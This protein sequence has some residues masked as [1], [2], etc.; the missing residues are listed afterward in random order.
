MS[1][2]G[3]GNAGFSDAELTEILR[4]RP[5]DDPQRQEACEILVGR[6]KNL[7]ESCVFRYRDVPE[8]VED[9]MQVGYV[10]LMKAINNYDPEIGSLAAYAQPSVSGEIKRYFRDKRWHMRVKRPAQELR[11]RIRTAVAELTQAL[12]RSPRPAELAEHLQVSEAEITE[13][14]LASEVFQLPSLDSPLG[15]E[16]DGG[17]LADQ[18][19]AEDPKLEHTLDMQAVWQH[20][21]ELPER[22]QRLL[23]MRFYG[24]MT[25]L[26]IAEKLGVSQM[27]VSRLLS[28]ALGYLRDQIQATGEPRAEAPLAEDAHQ[29][30]QEAAPLG[31]ISDPGGTHAGT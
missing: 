14:L 5:L 4:S 11:L 7:V 10:G 29:V 22:E 1:V 27:H 13:A 28:R 12:A 21:A 17:T 9:L 16:A 20:A 26:Q 24:N 25:Q 15:P 31:H 6:Y 2:G 3:K 8:S 23:M 18:V 19:G 30:Q